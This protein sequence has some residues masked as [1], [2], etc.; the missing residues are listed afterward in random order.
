VR[1]T[2]IWALRFDLRQYASPKPFNLLQKE[3]WLRQ[4]EVSAGIGVVF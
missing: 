1:V 3:G 4:T 2:G